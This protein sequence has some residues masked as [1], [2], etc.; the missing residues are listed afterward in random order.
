MKKKA[1]QSDYRD[2]C[3]PLLKKCTTN[4][5]IELSFAFAA[6]PQKV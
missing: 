2:I 6:P 4:L 1:L 3:L 5:V